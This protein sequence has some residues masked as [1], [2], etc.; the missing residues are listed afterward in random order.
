MGKL[1]REATAQ[2]MLAEMKKQSTYQGNL[3]GVL[4]G[5]KTSDKSNLVA[6]IN[7]LLS[8]QGA[9]SSLSTTTKTSIAAAI[10]EIFAYSKMLKESSGAGLHNAHWRG[11]NIGTTLTDAQS[12]AIRAGTFDDMWVGDYINRTVPA[13]TWTDTGGTT[14]SESSVTVNFRFAGFD[15]F[16]K[17]GDGNTG[18]LTTHHVVVV[19]DGVLYNARMEATDTTANGYAGSEMY[20]NGLLRAKALVT[21]AFGSAHILSH[22]EWLTNGATSGRPTAAAWHNS[23]VEL[24][25]EEMVYGCPIKQTANNGTGDKTSTGTLNGTIGKSQLP[26]FRLRPDLIV[27]GSGANRAWWWL[28]DIVDSLRFANVNHSGLASYYYA[29]DSGGGV[30][31]AF[32]LY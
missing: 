9:L 13:Y 29:S 32:L 18:G 30:R 21:A 31:P 15:Y 2:E 24:M 20:T 4:S 3:Q 14:H 19:P 22:R 27:A 8:N 1:F 28:R 7:E 5:L 16:L 6:A 17:C 12:T 26:L 10:N 23:T 25:N 11:K